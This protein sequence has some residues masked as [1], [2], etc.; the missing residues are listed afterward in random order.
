MLKVDF[1]HFRSGEHVEEW[2]EQSIAPEKRD[3][4]R[5]GG[6]LYRVTDRCIERHVV[7]CLVALEEV[8]KT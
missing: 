4:V 3:L 8:Q 1:V 6:V 7:L 2:N 5:L